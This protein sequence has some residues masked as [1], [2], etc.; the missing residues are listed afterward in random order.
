MSTRYT[1]GWL[2]LFG[3]PDNF[4]FSQVWIKALTMLY[5][6][7]LVASTSSPISKDQSRWPNFGGQFK[8]SDSPI[9]CRSTSTTTPWGNQTVKAMLWTSSRPEISKTWM[10]LGLIGKVDQYRDAKTVCTS[11]FIN[12]ALMLLCRI[13][14]MCQFVTADS[15][16]TCGCCS[17][18]LLA[19]L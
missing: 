5:C 6:E 12:A 2:I 15:K 10:P 14:S 1:H 7:N 16:A 4:I 3:L 9:H 8:T 18:L 13:G 17:S 11:S 19:S